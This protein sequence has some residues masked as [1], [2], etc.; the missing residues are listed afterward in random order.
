MQP[1]DEIHLHMQSE[2]EL[3]S[4][5]IGLASRLNVKIHNMQLEESNLETLFLQLTGRTLRE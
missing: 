5:I 1:D 4:A 2:T 3:L